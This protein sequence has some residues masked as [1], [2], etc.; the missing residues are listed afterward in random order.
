M[1]W[2]GYM[3]IL[4]GVWLVGV[5]IGKGKEVLEFYLSVIAFLFVLGVNILFM[6]LPIV[7]ALLI[8][9]WIFG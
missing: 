8:L 7:V 1:I 6:A 3:W 5:L 2:V 4:L 9:G